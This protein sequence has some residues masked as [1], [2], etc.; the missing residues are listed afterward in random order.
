MRNEGSVVAANVEVR[1]ELPDGLTTY[2]FMAVAVTAGDRFGTAETKVTTNKPLM[3]RAKLPTA[4]RT[5]DRFKVAA[6]V[7]LQPR[8]A[9]SDEAS[10]RAATG[11]T[12]ALVGL[13]VR[14]LKLLGSDQHRVTLKPNVAQRV[15][16]DVS[17][18]TAGSYQVVLGA[19][20]T[21]R[22]GKPFADV[23]QKR[24]EVKTPTYVETASLH[25]D[26]TR[27]VAESLGDLRAL[28]PDVGELTITLA[29][30]RLVGLD[31]NIHQLLE[32]PY[33]CTEQTASRMLP[34]LS[35]RQLATE[36]RADLPEDT[37]A[38][39]ARAVRRLHS[40]QQQDGG[41]GAWPGSRQ[42]DPWITAYALWALDQADR[43]GVVVPPE[44]LDEPTRFLK[45]YLTK[46]TQRLA[47]KG[48]DGAHPLPAAPTAQDLTTAA[49]ALDVL[50]GRGAYDPVEADRLFAARDQL[51]PFA[52]ALLL[53][54]MASGHSIDLPTRQVLT[55]D[56]AASVR[57]SGN[58]AYALRPDDRAAPWQRA[59]LA[60]DTRSTALLLRALVAAH[61][62]H[63][64]IPK[65]VTGLLR[66]LGHRRGTTTQDNAW[67]LTALEAYRQAHPSTDQTFDA[68]VFWNDELLD[69]TRFDRDGPLQSRVQVPVE[70]LA[71]ARASKLTF[72]VSGKG[73]LHYQARLRFA[74]R[75]LPTQPRN[76]GMAITRA[77]RPVAQ[78]AGEETP[79]G[80][81]KTRFAA[82]DLVRVDLQVVTPAPRHFV[83]L[84]DPLPGGLVAIDPTLRT[85]LVETGSGSHDYDH[86]E[87]RD[88]RVLFFVDHLP[89][90]I[91]TFSYWARAR[92]PG[93]YVQPP[94]VIQEMYA[95]EIRGATA[96]RRIHV[97]RR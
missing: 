13:R 10:P 43:G 78:Y 57:L 58:G 49:F 34:L 72:D 15:E 52:K 53:H 89:A 12:E 11:T 73:K 83:V 36:V 68:R 92:N 60:S 70:K 14:G 50:A 45:S 39:L 40:H 85:G 9:D 28:R 8:A 30:T 71:R 16:F 86:R 27:P 46:A 81:P 5:G 24:G 47:T 88:D 33:G 38:A 66:Q 90:G 95:P 17:A 67:A 65:L 59:V 31:Q 18:T 20:T 22:P 2:R 79:L 94:T 19:S 44:L 21:G 82:G 29:K 42:S 26:T 62:S 87:L 63:P 84:E 91:R 75:K 80:A 7:T 6:L 74:R 23:V 25:G 97:R 77:M 55:N 37:D 54:G 69:Q 4:I 32:Y 48:A 61:P 93:S 1:D 41:F 35:L 96:G 56:L 76:A 3:V 51:P 64:L